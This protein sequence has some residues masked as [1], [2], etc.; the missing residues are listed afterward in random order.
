VL[1]LALALSAFAGDM[2]TTVVSSP[3]PPTE[4]AMTQGDI[5]TTVAGDMTTGVTAIEPATEIT[6]NLLQ[7]LL[8]LF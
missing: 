5:S 6:L 7:S 8:S 3:P 2:S 1:I 4:Q